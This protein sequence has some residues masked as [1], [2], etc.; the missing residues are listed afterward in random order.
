MAAQVKPQENSDFVLYLQW[1]FS[2][3]L[4]QR[5]FFSPEFCAAR[6]FSLS[7]VIS[8]FT[9]VLIVCHVDPDT[10]PEELDAMVHVYDWAVTRFGT[11]VR[12]SIHYRSAF[13]HEHTESVSSLRINASN[14]IGQL[15]LAI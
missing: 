1:L 7:R 5:I 14:H 2:S 11:E 13:S 6:L 10:A 3:Q 9:F 12:L 4:S 8:A 15:F